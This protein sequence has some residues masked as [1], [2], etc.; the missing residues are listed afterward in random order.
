MYGLKRIIMMIQYKN[1]VPVNLDNVCT[2]ELFHRD[3]KAIP[4]INS[5]IKFHYALGF[6]SF[7]KLDEEA[8]DKVYQSIQ[9]QFVTQL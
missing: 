7:W 5:G 1:K 6:S 4:K 8:R 9:R 2:I 3:D